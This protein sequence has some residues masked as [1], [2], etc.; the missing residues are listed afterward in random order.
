MALSHTELIDDPNWL[1]NSVLE[2][3]IFRYALYGDSTLTTGQYSP[4]DL[5]LHGVT[6]LTGY[7][8]SEEQKLFIDSIFLRLDPLLAIDFRHIDNHIE[9]DII[10]YRS[11][12]NSF[13]NARNWQSS[14]NPGG[15]F[16]SLKTNGPNRVIWRDIYENDAFYS[17]EKGSIVHEIGHTLNLDHPAGDGY[18]PAWTQAESIMSYN[19]KKIED[20]LYHEWFS[21]LDI[22]ALQSIWGVEDP[23]DTD[24]PTIAISSSE[25]LLKAGNQADITFTLSENSWDFSHSD[26]VI[27][28]GVL[29]DWRQISNKIYKASF[30]PSKGVSE[31]TIS[32]KTNS[33]RDAPLNSGPAAVWW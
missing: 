32:V 24:G 1:E 16:A 17:I 30:E 18:N 6:A 11:N 13:G 14:D 7:N 2:E 31:A 19:N 22:Q 9:A 10:I 4:I 21:E 33:F 27:S 26:I 5:S 23:T 12:S 29:S 25:S 28:G 20:D 8:H 3:K 15:A